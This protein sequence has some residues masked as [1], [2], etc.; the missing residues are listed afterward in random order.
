M[1]DFNDEAK[2]LIS[3]KSVSVDGNE[4]I[5]NYLFDRM[6]ELG[7]KVQLQ[8]VTHSLDHISKRQFNVIGILGDPLVDKKTKKGLLLNTHLDT[9]G[10]GILSNWT[11]TNG[12]PWHP[13]IKDGKIF[14]LGSADVKLDFLCKLRAI[15]KFREK[16]L[17][18]PIYLVGTCGEEIGMLGAKYLIKSGALNPKF[19]VVGEP[20]D[21]SVVYA[22]KSLNIFKINIGFQMVAKDA[23]GFN[24]RI[25]IQSFGKS[26]HGSYPHLGTNAITQLMDLIRD[27]ID[28]GYDMKFTKLEGGDSVNKVPDH[29]S[30][31]FYLTSHQFEDYKRFFKDLLAQTQMEKSFEMDYSG[32][33][34]E[35]IRF[36]PDQIFECATQ[37]SNYFKKLSNQFSK[38]T[39]DS[40]SPS[41]STVNLGVIN[42]TLGGIELLF[43]LRILPDQ[44]ADAIEKEILKDIL[45]LAGQYAGLNVSAVRQRTNPGLNMTVEH[46]LV[47]ICKDA[48]I[49][50]GLPAKIDKKA[51]S[52]EAAQYY[53]AGFEAVIFGPGL[54]QGNSHSPNEHNLMEQLDKATAFYEKL[55][56]RVCL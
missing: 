56:E 54:S 11:E 45:T 17:K 35:G 26:A 6:K 1:R 49:S 37:I 29:A 46:E 47:R 55:I 51:T 28:Q 10:G 23:R 40:Y 41:F 42:Q 25:R 13:V 50:A 19:V 22:H 15:E 33:G 12:D 14:G 32:G 7:L 5:A 27:S 34:E 52:T 9:V 48:L 16:K 30:V 44:D 53:K 20:S 39:D 4:E 21:L 18:M 38:V 36:V 24:R 3:L 8:H 2:K 31:E 43:D